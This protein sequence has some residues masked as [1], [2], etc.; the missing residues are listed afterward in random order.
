MGKIKNGLIL[1]CLSL[2]IGLSSCSFIVGNQ[3]NNSNNSNN[4][5]SGKLQVLN[6][7]VDMTQLSSVDRIKAEYLIKNQGYLSDD[8]VDVI[9]ELDDDALIDNYL[10]NEKDYESVGAYAYSKDGGKATTNINKA[11]TSLINSLTKKGLIKEIDHQYRTIINGFSTSIKYGDLQK[12]EGYTGIKNVV[13]QDTYNLPQS[14]KSNTGS[15][16]Q[17]LVDVYETGIFNSSTVD[18]DGEGTAVAILDSGFDC[19][20]EVFRLQPKYG[21]IGQS[22]IGEVLEDSNAYRLTKDLKVTDVWYSNKI[23]FAYD[24]ADKDPDVTPY[25]SE[26]G[27]HV[28][29]IIGGYS[30]DINKDGITG[31][32]INT[33]LVLMKVFPNLSS[34]Y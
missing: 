1:S 22:Q 8:I 29:G 7:N 15:A 30:Q 18:Y 28:A 26:H 3:T 17:N 20:H 23:P 14:T 33:Q 24:Y 27:T 32:A 6:A 5:T 9:I 4:E 25:D 10:E 2:M 19:S 34:G 31:V 16:V 12:L 11:Q 21:P 13:I